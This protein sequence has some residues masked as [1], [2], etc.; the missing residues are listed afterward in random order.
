MVLLI[1]FCILKRGWYL[2]AK[3]TTDIYRVVHVDFTTEKYFMCCFRDGIVK[4]LM[5]NPVGPTCSKKFAVKIGLK[6]S[7]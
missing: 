5:L 6:S 4:S 7:V 2:V 3:I 1:S